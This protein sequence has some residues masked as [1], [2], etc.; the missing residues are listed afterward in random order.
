MKNVL[1]GGF[2]SLIGSIW[3][4]A[5]VFLTGNQLVDSWT[6][7]PGRFLTTVM[8]MDLLFVFILSV[9]LVIAGIAIMANELFHKEK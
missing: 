4:L 2:T 5:I 7:P 1:I 8:E 3:A 9:V 6:N